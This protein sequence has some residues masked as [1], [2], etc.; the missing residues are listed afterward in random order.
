MMGKFLVS[1]TTATLLLVT[2]PAQ[3]Q[4]AAPERMLAAVNAARAGAG[5]SPVT[6]NERLTAAACR[7]ARDLGARALHDV[8]ALSHQGSDGSDLGGRLRDAGYGFR[9]AAENLAAGVV[10]PAETVRLWLASD[11]HRRNMLTAGFR[12]VGIGHVAPRLSPGGNPIGPMAVWVLVLATPMGEPIE[13]KN[14]KD[15]RP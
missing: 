5:L 10:D 15:C 9:A 2:T 4:I 11:G 7:Q 8:A 14:P 1:L 13:A 12:E 6:M 3:A